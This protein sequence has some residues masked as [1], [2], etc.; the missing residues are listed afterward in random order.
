[1]A[2]NSKIAFA[3]MLSQEAEV[4]LRFGTDVKVSLTI[5]RNGRYL[6]TMPQL[7]AALDDDDPRSI[8][9]WGTL[10]GLLDR[11]HPDTTALE[12]QAVS[13]YSV[14]TIFGQVMTRVIATNATNLRFKE[15]GGKDR[16]V[17][18]AMDQDA[19]AYT[20]ELQAVPPESKN[21]IA[22]ATVNIF[23][24]ASK[25][26]KYGTAVAE[27]APLEPK[28]MEMYDDDVL[29]RSYNEAKTSIQP[30]IRTT[31]AILQHLDIDPE[32][33]E[34]EAKEKKEQEKKEAAEGK[35]SEGDGKEEATSAHDRTIKY[36]DIQEGDGEGDP[37]GSKL[38]IEYEDDDLYTS[39][40]YVPHPLEEVPTLGGS[41]RKICPYGG[42]KISKQVAN[43]L[44]VKSQVRWQGGKRTG[45]LRN[46]SLAKAASD[47]HYH[48]PFKRKVDNDTLDTAVLLLVDTS[49][50]MSGSRYNL[51]TESAV[52]FADVLSSV[53]IPFSVVGFTQVFGGGATNEMLVH[54]D[55]KQQHNTDILYGSLKQGEDHFGNNDDGV[56]LE[57]AHSYINAQKQKRK[58]IIVLSDGQ[59]SCHQKAG[60]PAAYLKKVVHDVERD[61]D[62]FAIGIETRSVERF[63]TNYK[64]LKDISKL[65]ETV[66]N[67][68]R[69]QI[70]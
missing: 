54:K 65:E 18:A 61:I 9:W 14:D 63:Y 24:Q 23:D 60:S 59:P 1:M 41:V 38:T 20:Q 31:K 57:W 22:L 48:T 7:D 6:I 45:R 42:D 39:D 49:G 13:L 2:Y 32:K 52:K 53:H 30:I 28:V 21:D 5:Q 19:V 35:P 67:T 62:L 26:L 56:A 17:L 44:K 25:M 70:I 27:Y 64:V 66:I 29:V 40:T 46:R 34:E 51:A 4:D 58:I 43:L 37:A 11:L 68:L 47:P 12:E 15:Y 3:H 8:W 36:K 55:F 33:A 16:W 50:S 10:C 69:D